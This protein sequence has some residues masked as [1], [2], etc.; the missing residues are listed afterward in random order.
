[1]QNYEDIKN[2]S[3]PKERTNAMCQHAKERKECVASSQKVRSAVRHKLNEI[4]GRYAQEP[5]LQVE[6]L[7]QG[8]IKK[9]KTTHKLPQDYEIDFD[10]IKIEALEKAIASAEQIN[11]AV[12]EKVFDTYQHLVIERVVEEMMKKDPMEDID[13]WNYPRIR[14]QEFPLFVKKWGPAINEIAERILDD[15]RLNKETDPIDPWKYIDE[16]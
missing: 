11:G 7:V 9:I 12:D 8:G 13:F 3:N 6:E 5:S 14:L 4:Y 16:E 2:I 15:E 1:M 10:D